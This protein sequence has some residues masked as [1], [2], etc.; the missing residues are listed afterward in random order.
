MSDPDGASPALLQRVTRLAQ[1][2]RARTFR[3]LWL[4]QLTSE[5]G[6][7]AGR[8]A[9]SVLVL[10]R[11][12]SAVLTGAVATAAM[13][14]YLG[15]GQALTAVLTRVRTRRALI[16]CDVARAIVFAVIAT[17]T[18]PWLLLVLAFCSG[19]FTVPFES[20]RSGYLPRTV[21]EGDYG[22]ALAV[23]AITAEFSLFAGYLAGGAV[24]A[25]VGARTAL[26]VNAGS[27]AASALLLL[28]LPRPRRPA[29]AP[30]ASP[31][32]H[33]RETA[34]YLRADPIVRRFVS[35]YAIVC[36]CALTGETLA[37]VFV[38]SDLHKGAGVVG[39]LSACV[40]A[41]V[42][43]FAIAAPHSGSH[44]TLVRS[45]AVMGM[46]GGAVAAAL[47]LV[48]AALPLAVLPY[49]ALGAVFASRLPGLQAVGLRIP[50]ELRATAFGLM[51]GALAVGSI[52]VPPLA[53][54]ISD[55]VGIRSTMV[56]FSAAAAGVAAI[57]ALLPLRDRQ[58]DEP[59]LK[60]NDADRA[61]GGI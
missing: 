52:V 41:G 10:E 55:V 1:P 51:A 2:L 6:D 18:S 40:S 47:F 42:I 38:A 61:S 59:T 24:I 45:G 23:A 39:V 37:P 20:L 34:A 17:A 22:N 12:G 21:P 3:R 26:A 43:L 48:D 29:D 5:L 56:I 60:P 33:V 28:G 9:L 27:F 13:A 16:G 36:G 46:L 4:A 15:P 58:T 31:L 30:I 7:W 44:D 14:P 32:A 11:S 25:I 54:Y 57:A 49:V 19:L 53:G 8:I 50:D 35:Y